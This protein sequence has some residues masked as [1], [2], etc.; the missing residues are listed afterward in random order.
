MA[1]LG[2]LEVDFKQ[3]GK[4]GKTVIYKESESEISENEWNFW[5]KRTTGT[6]EI[7][8]YRKVVTFEEANQYELEND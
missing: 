4:E 1:I 7:Y 8:V 3:L 2:G 5:G 6:E